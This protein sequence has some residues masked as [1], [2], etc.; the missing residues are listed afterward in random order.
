MLILPS[1][2]SAC[3]CRGLGLGATVAGAHVVTSKM[4][5]ACSEALAS[6]LTP[7]ERYSITR[8]TQHLPYA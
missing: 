5:Y 4:M 2:L 8:S 3:G 1:P 6:S 7:E